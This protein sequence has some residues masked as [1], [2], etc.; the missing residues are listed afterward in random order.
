MFKHKNPPNLIWVNTTIY[1]SAPRSP[2]LGL[3]KKGI[4][5]QDVNGIQ[6]VT[7]TGCRALTPLSANSIFNWVDHI[8]EINLA[9]MI[10]NG[11]RIRQQKAIYK[12]I[13][14]D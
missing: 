1:R 14:R 10:H 5:L 9:Q 8:A 3:D 12:K 7:S 13:I 2:G 4:F 6:N 11:K